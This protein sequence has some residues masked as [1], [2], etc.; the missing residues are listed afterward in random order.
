ML[1]SNSHCRAAEPQATDISYV[2]LHHQRRSSRTVKEGLTR[3]ASMQIL[4]LVL[5]GSLSE[6]SNEAL[7]TEIIAAE[8][9]G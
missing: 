3:S 1:N 9:T 8:K 5:A 7:K 2:T 4:K 6:S